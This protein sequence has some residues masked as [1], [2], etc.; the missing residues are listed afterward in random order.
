MR[1]LRTGVLLLSVAALAAYCGYAAIVPYNDGTMHFTVSVEQAR[2]AAKDWA[3][4]QSLVL[5]LTGVEMPD[6]GSSRPAEYIFFTSDSNQCFRVCTST[7]QIRR[8]YDKTLRN[9]YLSHMRNGFDRLEWLPLSELD[10]NVNAFLSTRYPGF[11]QYNMTSCDSGDPCAAYAE[12]A[13]NGVWNNYRTAACVIDQWTGVVCSYSAPPGSACPVPTQYT[14]QSSQAAQAAVSYILNKDWYVTDDD[15]SNGHNAKFAAAFTHLNLGVAVV[16]DS[17]GTARLVW[18]LGIVAHVTNSS[19]SDPD[20]VTDLRTGADM[21][22]VICWSVYVDANTGNVRWSDQDDP[23]FY[24]PP[25]APTPTFAPAAGTY[26]GTQS[27]TISCSESGA[28]IRYTTDGTKPTPT[29]TL[30]TGPVSVS[31]SQTLKARAHKTNF[32]SSLVGT[33]EYVIQ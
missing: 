33:A 22:D 24:D 7:G 14:V 4:D 20:F 13:T 19:Y 17:T 1:T 23:G 6:S 11:A 32:R 2:Q 29:S 15:G 27:V 16:P 28:T 31:T 8:W 5:N 26:T 9:A 10:A 21:D 3:G 25:S 30:Y 12:T 18:Q